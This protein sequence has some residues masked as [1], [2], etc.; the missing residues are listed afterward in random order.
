MV[1]KIF[2]KNYPEVKGGGV[3][4]LFSYFEGKPKTFFV[5]LLTKSNNITQ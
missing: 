4:V 3:K 5:K 2:V 1:Q